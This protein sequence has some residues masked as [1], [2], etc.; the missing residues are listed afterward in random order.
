[1][2]CNNCSKRQGDKAAIIRG[3]Y[4][5]TI[6]EPCYQLL[7]A[8]Q[9]VSSG[10]ANWNRTIDFLDHEADVIQPLEDGKPSRRFI[11]L[12]PEKAQA[13]FTPEQLRNSV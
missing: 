11:E 5:K 12:Y 8:P 3:Q 2:T 13:M 9:R 6:C 10:E 1:M 4:Y 7:Q